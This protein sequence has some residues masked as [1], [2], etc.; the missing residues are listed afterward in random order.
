MG[1]D[2][3]AAGRR[4]RL[5]GA[6]FFDDAGDF[7]DSPVLWFYLLGTVQPAEVDSGSGGGGGGMQVGEG[8]GKERRTF[9]LT[10][11]Y[12]AKVEGITVEYS[13]SVQPQP[14]QQQMALEGRWINSAG[15]HGSFG[16]RR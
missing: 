3:A 13:G 14:S 1:G 4:R 2:G 9:S 12:E 11:A 15:P 7:A 16:C 8:G 10:K 5:F 6:G